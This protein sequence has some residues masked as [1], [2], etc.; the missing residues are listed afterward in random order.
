[1]GTKNTPGAFDCYA[2]AEPD[3]PMFILLGRD[4]DAASL[5]RLWALMRHAAGE[6]EKKV[7]EALQCA[8]AMDG[9]LR[10]IDKDPVAAAARYSEVFVKASEGMASHPDDFN[11]P[12]ACDEC[13][14][15]Q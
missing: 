2:N 12:C 13:C 5:V 14:S 7:T 3:E 1:M 4:R 10:K 9:W 15:Y 6:D 8:E 11:E